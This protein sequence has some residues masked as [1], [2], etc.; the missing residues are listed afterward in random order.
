MSKICPLFVAGSMANSTMVEH[1]QTSAVSQAIESM[2]MCKKER[3]QLWWLC[4]GDMKHLL[5]N[6]FN[7]MT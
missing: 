4:S 1:H 2:I 6:I 3:C 7:R 5:M